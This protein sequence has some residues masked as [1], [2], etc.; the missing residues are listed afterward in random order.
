MLSICPACGK[1]YEGMPL[2]CPHCRE[3]IMRTMTHMPRPQLA[4]PPP[5]APP[6]PV[7]LEP[8]VPPSPA[9]QALRKPAES[10]PPAV[11]PLPPRKP[12]V[13]AHANPAATTG[14]DPE[15]LR[16]QTFKGIDISVLNIAK[17][18]YAIEV[19][20]TSNR[21]VPLFSMIGTGKK[22]FGRE[23]GS[24][25]ESLKTLAARHIQFENTS[26]GLFIKPGNSLNGVYQ[27]VRQPVALVDGLSIRISNYILTFREA[28]VP[29]HSEPLV[30]EG[31]HLLVR[32]LWAL[33]YLEFLRPDDRPGVRFPILNPVA[34]IIGRGGLDRENR[35]NDVDLPLLDDPKVSRRHARITGRGRDDMRLTLT[36]L[37]SETGTWVKVRERTL[38]ED[39]DELWLGEIILRVAA[40]N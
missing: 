39:G 29:E 5:V 1:S 40:S 7:T 14:G 4:T 15:G 32:D 22:V 21:W 33:G 18:N 31:E 20:D 9:P 26:R 2:R 3:M 28:L 16:T 36:D 11:S 24:S 25:L 35:E 38:V 27:R 13:Q 34:T 8:P 19:F 17:H 10:P 6:A 37:D 12:A 30:L 23:A